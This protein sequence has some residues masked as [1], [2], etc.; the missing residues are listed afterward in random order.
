MVRNYKQKTAR[1][2]VQ[3]NAMD[4]AVTAVMQFLQSVMQAAKDFHVPYRTLALI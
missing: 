4:Q 3:S 1:G 2:N